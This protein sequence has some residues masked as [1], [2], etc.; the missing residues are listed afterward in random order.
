MQ[1]HQNIFLLSYTTYY[2]RKLLCY[3][4][5]YVVE[6]EATNHNGQHTI[7]LGKYRRRRKQCKRFFS[8]QKLTSRHESLDNLT[9]LPNDTRR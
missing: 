1:L 8:E 6:I 9:E 4:E 2:L 5:G 7:R 3:I